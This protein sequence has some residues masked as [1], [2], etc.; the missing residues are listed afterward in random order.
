MRSAIL[1]LLIKKCIGIC[2]IEQTTWAKYKNSKF[3]CQDAQTSVIAIEVLST[4]SE[5]LLPRHG[6]IDWARRC[7]IQVLLTLSLQ[8]LYDSSL[9]LVRILSCENRINFCLIPKVPPLG[10]RY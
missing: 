8:M 3:R 6:Q 7:K 5:C 10:D 1:L 9:S 4:A 2:C